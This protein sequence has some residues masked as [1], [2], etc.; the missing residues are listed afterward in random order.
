MVWKTAFHQASALEFKACEDT[1]RLAFMAIV[2]V[3]REEGPSLG[4]PHV[5]TLQGSRHGNMK[6]FR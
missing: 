5:H 2:E 6:E 1:T 4:R 3:L